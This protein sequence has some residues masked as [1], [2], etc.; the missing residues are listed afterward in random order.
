V[1]TVALSVAGVDPLSAL[2]VNQ[3]QLFPSVALK[4]SPLE[5]FVLVND[6]L[7]GAGAVVAPS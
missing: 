1:F 2:R 6:M 4:E 7:C 5:G 3:L